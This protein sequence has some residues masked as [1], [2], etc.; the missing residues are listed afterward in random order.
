MLYKKHKFVK[1][2]DNH[3]FD[4]YSVYYLC[5]KYRSNRCKATATLKLWNNEER[6]FVTLKNTHNHVHLSNPE[7]AIIKGT[8]DLIHQPSEDEQSNIIRDSI[9][10][11]NSNIS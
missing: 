4:A 8:S 7:I 5:S 3:G 2:N 10:D 1:N 6:K 11:K 9:M